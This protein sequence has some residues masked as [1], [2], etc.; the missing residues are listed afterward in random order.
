MKLIAI[1]LIRKLNAHFKTTENIGTT[2]TLQAKIG[3]HEEEINFQEAAYEIPY[4]Y[5]Q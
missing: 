4:M 3:A 5:K 2:I 1:A